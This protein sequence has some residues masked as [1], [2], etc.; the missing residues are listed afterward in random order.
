MKIPKI[1]NKQIDILKLI[2][3]FRFL[4][5]TQ[6]QQFL[7]HKDKMRINLWLKD[8]HNKKYINRIYSNKIGDNTKPAIYYS[9]E[10]LF[11]FVR[12]NLEYGEKY[13]KNIYRDHQRS[14]GFIDR[15]MLVVDIC[16]SLISINNKGED[17][18]EFMTAADVTS[19]SNYNFMKS[20]S[21]Q[22]ILTKN[23]DKQYILVLL[24]S[25][26]PKYMVKKKIKNYIELF[27]EN[28]WEENVGKQFPT[29]LFASETKALLIFAKKTAKYLLA[30]YQNPEDLELWFGLNEDVEEH[31]ID[32]EVWEEMRMLD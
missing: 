20:L 31:G 7:N 4:N 23:E 26:M 5:S 8:L 11:K 29:V 15:Q 17:R 12:D 9:G 1:T 19:S 14:E 27:Y 30:D 2:Y 21:P 24:D 16:L 25:N 10:N 6:I 18:Y 3:R 28:A 22:L 13:L 32:A